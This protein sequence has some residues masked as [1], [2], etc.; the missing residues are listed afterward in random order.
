MTTC[1]IGA[2]GA[3]A[4]NNHRDAVKTVEVLRVEERV[5]WQRVMDIVRLVLG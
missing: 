2:A 1:W 4:P 5:S 3:V